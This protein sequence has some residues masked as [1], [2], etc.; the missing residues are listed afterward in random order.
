MQRFMCNFQTHFFQ[1]LAKLW[2]KLG[3]LFSWSI[4]FEI[5]FELGFLDCNNTPANPQAKRTCGNYSSNQRVQWNPRLK[6]FPYIYFAFY[7]CSDAYCKESTGEW[8]VMGVPLLLLVK[9]FNIENAQ[10]KI[11]HILYACQE[12]PLQ[13][14]RF[15][16]CRTFPTKVTGRILSTTIILRGT[17]IS[18]QN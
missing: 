14:R 7:Y 18:S 6:V 2:Y 4:S 16:N 12:T 8:N 9:E 13:H 11:P 15:S 3:S 1:L 17:I 5:N 10:I